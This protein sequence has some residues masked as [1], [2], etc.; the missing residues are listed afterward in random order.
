MDDEREV[1]DGP[2]VGS[3]EMTERRDESVRGRTRAPWGTAGAL[4]VFFL[5][6]PALPSLAAQE[7][8]FD[9]AC[10][11]FA[12]R[13]APPNQRPPSCAEDHHLEWWWECAYAILEG[14]PRLEAVP[15][16]PWRVVEQV[17]P[18]APEGQF[19]ERFGERCEELRAAAQAEGRPLL[20]AKYRETPH[21]PARCPCTLAEHQAWAEEC[22]ADIDA[23]LPGMR[24]W[25]VMERFGLDGGARIASKARFRHCTCPR[26]K[27]DVEFDLPPGSSE[28][29][30][31]DLV[32]SV[33]TPYLEY[34]ITD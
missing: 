16:D 3:T 31:R 17:K 13:P 12:P 9:G 5:V 25:E 4:A 8:I 15:D 10:S 24:R 33:S 23:I 7:V 6:W 19:A 29:S 21:D 27:V 34:P 1:I 2:M 32:R 22:L 20:D 26:L 30:P 28:E 11:L 18:W 14:R